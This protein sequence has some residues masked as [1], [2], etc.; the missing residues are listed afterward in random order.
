MKCKQIHKQLI[1]YIDGELTPEMTKNIQAHLNE[2]AECQKIY[3][4]MKRA[5]GEQAA[6][7]IPY[8]P[9][10][11]TRV[12]QGLKNDMDRNKRFSLQKYKRIIL[13]P[14]IYFVVL[15]LGIYLGIQLGQGAQ[16]DQQV[17]QNEISSQQEFIEAYADSQYINGM[18]LE[19]LEKEM[20]AEE[21]QTEKEENNE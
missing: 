17:A 2:C 19:I 14:A 11:Y 18:N 20:I 4:K 15:G 3:Q 13:Q 8:Q 6:A 9:F 1:F 21:Q 5:W 7:P 12:K 16:P 10:F